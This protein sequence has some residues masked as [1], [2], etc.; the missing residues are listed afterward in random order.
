MT[1]AD[2]D[3]A[4]V[5]DAGTACGAP[6]PGEPAEFESADTVVSDVRR[7]GRAFEG[8]AFEGWA[9]EGWA[10]EGWA[11]E[12]TALSNSTPKAPAPDV[13]VP[14]RPPAPCWV[15]RLIPGA[16][17]R[18]IDAVMMCPRPGQSGGWT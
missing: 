15:A 18:P 7:S 16:G 12:E 11:F 10:I 9:F 4:A 5:T 1:D 3:T 13:V 6:T 8:W 17:P 14:A 2:A